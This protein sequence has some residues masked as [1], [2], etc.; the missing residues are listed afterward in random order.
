MSITK[1]ILGEFRPTKVFSESFLILAI[2]SIHYLRVSCRGVWSYPILSAVK[3]EPA[4]W[5]QF[6][7]LDFA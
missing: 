1:M 2:V 6:I 5:E 3:S 7:K 4:D